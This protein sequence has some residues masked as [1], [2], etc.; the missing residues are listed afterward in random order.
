MLFT[1]ARAIKVLLA[2][3]DPCSAFY[4]PDKTENSE[5]MLAIHKQAG[6]I[7]NA[8]HTLVQSLGYVSVQLPHAG[9]INNR[10]VSDKGR[11]CDIAI[12]E[13][14][15]PGAPMDGLGIGRQIR[16]DFP[17]I[18]LILIDREAHPHN[19]ETARDEEVSTLDRVFMV[20]NRALQRG[21]FS[22]QQLDDAI[23][24]LTYRKERKELL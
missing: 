18:P 16:Q 1:L 13:M 5:I 11:E 3:P 21:V 4:D 12:C 7:H 23:R 24:D 14:S 17:K 20:F 8:Y 19:V 22:P 6:E 2:V 15:I 10:W 9:I